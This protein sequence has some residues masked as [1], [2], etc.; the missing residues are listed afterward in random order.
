MTTHMTD[1]SLA[2]TQYRIMHMCSC[3]V[4]SMEHILSVPQHPCFLRYLC[5]ARVALIKH[6]SLTNLCKKKF[7][8]M[9]A[10]QRVLWKRSQIQCSLSARTC[11][12]SSCDEKSQDHTK[13][14]LQCAVDSNASYSTLSY[15]VL[16][17]STHHILYSQLYIFFLGEQKFVYWICFLL[18][19]LR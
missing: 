18:N 11:F 5:S 6:L 9:Y 13:C 16:S 15:P 10:P 7:R 8:R 1:S 3:S 2:T 4:G 14:P 17:C 19:F 12:I